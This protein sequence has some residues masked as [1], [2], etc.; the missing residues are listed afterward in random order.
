MEDDEE[1]CRKYDD[2]KTM[3]NECNNIDMKEWKK[4]LGRECQGK[5]EHGLHD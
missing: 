1:E 3:K 2:K 4:I 5:R